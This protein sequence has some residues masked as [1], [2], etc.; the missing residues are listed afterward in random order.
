[1]EEESA[2]MQEGDMGMDYA[3]DDMGMQMDYGDEDAMDMDQEE[4]GDE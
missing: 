1:M 4:Y 2:M 3:E